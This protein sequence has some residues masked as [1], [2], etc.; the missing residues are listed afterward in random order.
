MLPQMP[1]S[2]HSNCSAFWPF[3]A[4]WTGGPGLRKLLGNRENGEKVR[5]VEGLLG[6]WEGHLVTGN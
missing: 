2:H 5:G 1:V 6:A 4:S 3:G